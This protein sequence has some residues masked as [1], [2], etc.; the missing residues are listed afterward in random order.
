[1]KSVVDDTSGVRKIFVGPDSSRR[2]Q[3]RYFLTGLQV[4][5]C[6]WLVDSQTKL[7]GEGIPKVVRRRVR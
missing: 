4:L 5:S 6:Q 3:I 7:K 2:V 1:M